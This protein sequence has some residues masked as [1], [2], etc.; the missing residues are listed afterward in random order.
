MHPAA[1]AL[2]ATALFVVVPD[3]AWACKPADLEAYYADALAAARGLWLAAAV[4]C[5]LICAIDLYRRT[6]SKSTITAV[7]ATVFFPAWTLPS[8]SFVSCTTM[9]VEGAVMVDGLLVFL[10]VRRL[11]L[12]FRARTK[13]GESA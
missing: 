1:K 13:P 2:I 6:L 7:L 12:T 5:G 10:L 9:N 11:W 3:A 4:L 8:W